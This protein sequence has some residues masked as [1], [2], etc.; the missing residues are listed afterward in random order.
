MALIKFWDNYA[1]ET[2]EKGETI[3][4]GCWDDITVRKDMEGKGY[5]KLLRLHVHARLRA[6]G[7]TFSQ[8]PAVRPLDEKEKWID[9][10]LTRHDW[11]AL[12]KKEIRDAAEIYPES[13]KDNMKKPLFE[14][15]V[16]RSI[17]ALA[18]L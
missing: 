6:A 1:R 7:C 16:R 8:F 13:F 4:I 5:A 9:F 18:K 10:F 15:T 12:V 14:V 2:N 11:G 3:K 17:T